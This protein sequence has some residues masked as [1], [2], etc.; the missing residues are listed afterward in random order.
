MSVLPAFTTLII[1][2]SLYQTIGAQ[3]IAQGYVRHQVGKGAQ[4]K[5]SHCSS[6]F[7][8]VY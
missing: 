1:G 8:D 4:F 7:L 5:A 3:Y 6:T 2:I